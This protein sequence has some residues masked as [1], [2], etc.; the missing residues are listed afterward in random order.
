MQLA[1]LCYMAYLQDNLNT[2][3]MRL[4]HYESTLENQTSMGRIEVWSNIF[5]YELWVNYVEQN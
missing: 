4:V 2:G 1:K 3:V 5:L